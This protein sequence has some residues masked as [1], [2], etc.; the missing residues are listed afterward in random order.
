V[1]NKFVVLVFLLLSCCLI[2]SAA[3]PPPV[4]SAG[5]TV[6][7]PGGKG[8][9]ILVKWHGVC[10]AVLPK[11]VVDNIQTQNLPGKRPAISVQVERGMKTLLSDN[12]W[13]FDRDDLYVSILKRRAPNECNEAPELK[14]LV[15][16][17]QKAEAVPRDPSVVVDLFIRSFGKS[18]SL[19]AK[20]VDELT[21]ILGNEYLEYVL[22]EC[23]TSTKSGQGCNPPI[24]GYSGSPI[25]MSGL[26]GQPILLGLH[27]ETCNNAVKCAYMD[28]PFWRATTVVQIHDFFAS[29]QSRGVFGENSDPQF[30]PENTESQS[31]TPDLVKRAQTELLRLN[32]EP[33]GADG[34]WGA[35]SIRALERFH[36]AYDPVGTVGSRPTPELVGVMT[37]LSAKICPDVCGPNEDFRDGICSISKRTAGVAKNKN[38]ARKAASRGLD[39]AGPNCFPFTTPTGVE[40]ACKVP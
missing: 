4:F 38:V 35:K 19:Q 37:N 17:L 32:C 21:R 39:N 29:L 12:S 3:S 28:K 31:E 25:W 34:I 33:G 24:D 11:H 8:Y 14:T 5:A 18:A 16:T 1:R 2:I 7:D 15:D 6:Q 30:Q 9:G 36:R 13:V 23:E 20:H 40:Y 22:R 10:T 27:R 26:N